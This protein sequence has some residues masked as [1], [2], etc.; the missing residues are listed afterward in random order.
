MSGTRWAAHRTAGGGWRRCSSA[1]S[2]SKWRTHSRSARARGMRTTALAWTHRRTGSSTRTLT[3]G[4]IRRAGTGT[5]EDG[6]ATLR[7]YGARGR[8]GSTRLSRRCRID[9][10]RSRLGNNQSS[11][12]R[13]GP[14]RSRRGLGGSNWRKR[15]CERARWLTSFNRSCRFYYHGHRLNFRF[16]NFGYRFNRN[17][18]LFF[19][20]R[21][22]RLGR[23]LNRRSN[24]CCR[25]RRNWGFSGNDNSRRLTYHGLW[26]DQAR[27]RFGRLS[28]RNWGGTGS[29]NWRL[30]DRAGRT[31]RHCRRRSYG[32]PWRRCRDS[33]SG[34]RRSNGLGGLLSNRLQHVSRLGDVREVDF[35]LEL[36]CGR[37]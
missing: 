33:C 17:R 16:D 1:G 34:A 6:L 31:R 29:G 13:G 7:H 15:G 25:R 9:R 22:M 24:G 11:R 4:L 23:F 26:R 35:G 18:D 8:G 12:R 20:Y 28:G 5:L 36:I 10:T 3:W 37:A 2:R 21:L 19:R 30:G 27:R 32:L 14:V